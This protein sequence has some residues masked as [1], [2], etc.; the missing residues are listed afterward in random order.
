MS[1]P[2]TPAVN[3][4]QPAGL[5]LGAGAGQGADLVTSASFDEGTRPSKGGRRTNRP[6]TD[7]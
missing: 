1:S 6:S 3:H 5:V 7:R 4:Q 2:N